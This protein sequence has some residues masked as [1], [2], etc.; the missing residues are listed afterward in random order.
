MD[1]KTMMLIGIGVFVILVIGVL[2]WWY[3][4]SAS[5]KP[6]NTPASNSTST[7]G[8]SGSGTSTSGS[9]T[10][11]AGTGAPSTSGSGTPT[12]GTGAPS[13]P[14]T[15]Q[16]LGYPAGYDQLTPQQQKIVMS[17]FGVVGTA[18]AWPRPNIYADTSSNASMLQ[19][20]SGVAYASVPTKYT[21]V[22]SASD[23][24]GC[25][26]LCTSTNK[27]VAGKYYYAATGPSTGTCYGAPS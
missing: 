14:T 5:A 13:T 27:C 10:S 25:S 2:V 3:Y 18:P 16:D 26:A 24:R 9:G 4:S 20:T 19:F 7:S 1:Q 22:G 23:I 11:G 17:G 8:T 6:T 12:T 15:Q 21:S